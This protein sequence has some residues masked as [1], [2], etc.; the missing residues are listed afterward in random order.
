MKK[1]NIDIKEAPASAKVVADT[2]AEVQRTARKVSGAALASI[3]F[4]AVGY[5]VMDANPDNM[6]ASAMY[7]LGLIS[8][9]ALHLYERGPMA[10]Q[11]RALS[12]V[13]DSLLAQAALLSAACPTARAYRDALRLQKR[14]MIMAEYD[15]LER[16]AAK[17]PPQSARQALY[18]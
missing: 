17:T 14:E 15:A 13:P 8:F 12:P 6:L 9:F 3:A 5:F 16:L 2:L 7:A 4:V 11:V 10:R 1:L 18:G